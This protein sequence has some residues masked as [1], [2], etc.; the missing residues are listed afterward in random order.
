MI[1]YFLQNQSGY[2]IAMRT[3]TA[4]FALSYMQRSWAE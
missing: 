3:P 1:I 2:L 4:G